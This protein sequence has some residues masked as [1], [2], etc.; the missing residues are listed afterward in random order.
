MK[1]DIRSRVELARFAADRANTGTGASVTIP[2]APRGSGAVRMPAD[3]IAQAADSQNQREAPALR[4]AS[5][6]PA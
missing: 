3:P 4:P 2:S 6:R 5:A 1:I